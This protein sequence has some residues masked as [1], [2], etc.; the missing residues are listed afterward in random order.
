MQFS[1][2]DSSPA[3]ERNYGSIKRTNNL[4]RTKMFEEDVASLMSTI[5]NIFEDAHSQYIKW[6]N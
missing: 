1:N 6:N 3:P 5:D 4:L 2:N